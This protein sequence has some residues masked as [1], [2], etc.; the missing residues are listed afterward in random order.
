VVNLSSSKHII[1][2]FTVRSSEEEQVRKAIAL[3]EKEHKSEVDDLSQAIQLS[4]NEQTS[5]LEDEDAMLQQALLLS[6]IE[7]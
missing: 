3:S 7:K 1:Y 4:I 5:N 2:F 6:A